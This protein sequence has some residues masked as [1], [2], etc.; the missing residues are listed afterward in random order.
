MSTT[1]I[2]LTEI[3]KNRVSQAAKRSGKTAH[4]YILDAIA[5]KTEQ[6]EKRNAFY[7]LAEQ[8]Y[9]E[10]ADSGLTLSWSEMREHLEARLSGRPT[11]KPTPRKLAR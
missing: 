4:S 7:D 9:G 3:L 10:V 2:R 5:E 1:T 8:R 11:K 6:D